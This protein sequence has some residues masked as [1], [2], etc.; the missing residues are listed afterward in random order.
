MEDMN[1]SKM[2]YGIVETW[3]SP[4]S[5]STEGV[6][7]TTSFTMVSNLSR[8]EMLLERLPYMAK[9]LKFKGTTSSIIATK[10][11]EKV[12]TFTGIGSIKEL[13]DAN[14]DTKIQDKRWISN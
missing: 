3:K 14:H 13:L 11:I 1:I 7:N 8:K 5:K 4:Q 10:E 9:I 6:T 2:N 12:T